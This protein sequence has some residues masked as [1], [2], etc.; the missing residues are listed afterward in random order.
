[1]NR[2]LRAGLQYI[3]FLGGGLFLV[4]WQ[5]RGMTPLER[6]SFYQSLKQANY[7]LVL[8]VIF[9]ALL[10]HLFRSLRW[11]LLMEPMGYD[12]A[13]RNVF[14]A[15]MVG[16]LANAAI[17]RLGEILK[18]SALAKYENLRVDRLVGTIIIERLFDFVCYL[19]FI[20]LTILIQLDLVG[21]FVLDMISPADGGNAAEAFLKPA[22]IIA[23]LIS[24]YFIIRKIF[25]RF[26]NNPIIKK[27]RQVMN[28]ISEGFRTIRALKKQK[29]FLSYTL[30][31]WFLYFLQIY[32]G[33]K[34]MDETSG[35][36]IRAGFSVL[37]LAT[38]AM[39]ITPGGIGSFPVFVMETLLLYGIS[40]PIGNAFGWLMWGVSTFIIIIAG[41]I[42]MLALP[43]MNRQPKNTVTGAQE[44]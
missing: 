7:W 1:M 41:L 44:T 36:G 24:V 33:F 35:L 32:I 30:L 5:L 34:A 21:G 26:P 39:I 16:Y 4:W 6:E 3:I 17:P 18:C 8:P 27:I 43:M 11:K 10:S 14:A 28:G 23:L 13:V 42:S 19:F 29:A 31:I 40:T 2:K 12:P 22:I 20:A 15:T 9:I 37:T 25:F 38:L